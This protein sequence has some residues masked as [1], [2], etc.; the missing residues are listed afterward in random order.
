MAAEVVLFRGKE[1]ELS[2]CADGSRLRASLKALDCNQS[3]LRG[4]L[5]LKVVSVAFSDTSSDR[6]FLI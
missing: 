6:I 4:G 3:V 2:G 1:R 5:D